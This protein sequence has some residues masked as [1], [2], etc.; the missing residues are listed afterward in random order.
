MQWTD[1]SGDCFC[2]PKGDICQTMTMSDEARSNEI[3]LAMQRLRNER[4]LLADGFY[5]V[6]R[7]GAELVLKRK[8]DSQP[9]GRLQAD[10]T[11]SGAVVALPVV[12]LRRSRSPFRQPD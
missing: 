6:V 3:R 1:E 2:G 9:V 12:A 5:Y 4:P 11:K 10:Y 7:V 8:C